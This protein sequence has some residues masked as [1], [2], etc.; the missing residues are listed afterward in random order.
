MEKKLKPILIGVGVLIVVIIMFS[1]MVFV[2]L[3][4]GEKGIIF[5]KFAGGLDKENVYGAGFHVIAPWNEMLVYDVKEQKVDEKKA[6]EFGEKELAVFGNEDLVKHYTP[7]E[8]NKVYKV[9]SNVYS[10]NM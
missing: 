9:I 7:E 4:P 6:R 5:K 10:L 3:Q 2:T 1:A 8:K